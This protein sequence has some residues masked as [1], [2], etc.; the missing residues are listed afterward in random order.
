MEPVNMILFK[1]GEEGE[2]LELLGIQMR[3]GNII[4][5]SGEAATCYGCG[6]KMT[7]HNLGNVMPGSKLIFCDNPACFASY[8]SEKKL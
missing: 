7:T 4:D 1:K 8:I 6:T 5:E 3:D 2:V